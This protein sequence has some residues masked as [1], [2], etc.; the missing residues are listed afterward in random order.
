MVLL[1]L[2]VLS[3]HASSPSPTRGLS[4]SRPRPKGPIHTLVLT[5]HGDSYWNGK[6][7]GCRETFTGWTDVGLSPVGETE[8]LRTGRILAECT[9]RVDV[10][11]TSALS[12]ARMT[13]HRCWWAYND[14]LEEEYRYQKKYQ[15]YNHRPDDDGMAMP[16]RANDERAHRPSCEAPSRFV[17]DHRLNERHYGSLQGLIKAEVESGMHGHIPED[18]REWRRSWHAVPPPLSDDDPRRIEELRLFG[19][20]CGGEWN[21]PR[22]ESLAMVANNRI[23]PFLAE[24]LTPML[25]GACESKSPS[26]SCTEDGTGEAT[27]E[28]G[29]A[30]IVAHANSL[31]ALIGVICNVERDPLGLALERLESMKIPTASPL[32]IRYRRTTENDCYFPV[33]D[34]LGKGTRNELPVYPL[35]SLP[36]LKN[37]THRNG[38]NPTV[39][40]CQNGAVGV[41]NASLVNMI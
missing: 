31:R 25:D 12:R 41:K 32:V 23:R 20:I 9:G 30:L 6:H 37:R 8:A 17:I 26:S 40:A 1:L 28:G 24:K 4:P 2:F 21:V 33:D 29:T 38:S 11:F 39:E 34:A 36:L 19:N 5:R 3:I 27:L 10:M 18:V 7:P 14:R 22:G 16:H 35:S 15:Y 13:A